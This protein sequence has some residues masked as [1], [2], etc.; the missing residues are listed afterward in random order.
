MVKALSIGGKLKGYE[1]NYKYMAMSWVAHTEKDRAMFALIGSNSVSDE[2]AKKENIIF[3]G[4]IMGVSQM[5]RWYQYD[6]HL[7]DGLIHRDKKKLAL[8]DR[9]N[10][11]GLRAENGL[12]I[13][14]LVDAEKWARKCIKEGKIKTNC[15]F[16]LVNSDGE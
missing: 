10:G 14:A 5:I 11:E 7:K 16:D 9:R 12:F 4:E 13:P 6:L 15:L 3:D 8:I 1:S 2:D